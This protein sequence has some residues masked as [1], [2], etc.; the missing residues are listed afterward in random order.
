MF[1]K[2]LTKNKFDKVIIIRKYTFEP[3]PVLIFKQN[4]GFDQNEM[5]IVKHIIR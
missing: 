5:R 4:V 3:V 1:P 2:I